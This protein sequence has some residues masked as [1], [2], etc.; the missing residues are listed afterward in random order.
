[1]SKDKPRVWFIEF[2][3]DPIDDKEIG[4]RCVSAEMFPPLCPSSE[5]IAVV[6]RSA[7][8]NLEEENRRLKKAIEYQQDE[9]RRLDTQPTDQVIIDEQGILIGEQQDIIDKLKAAFDIE[10]EKR[11]DYQDALKKIAA[12]FDC[13]YC[14]MQQGNNGRLVC[15]E[16]L[17][18][19]M[20]TAKRAL[21]KYGMENV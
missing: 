10:V 12:Y 7:Y 3:G 8:D 14:E 19:R 9:Y 20:L 2:S 15:E 21:E 13:L 1:M 16:H 11:V 5:V 4:N 6:E 18:E 17:E